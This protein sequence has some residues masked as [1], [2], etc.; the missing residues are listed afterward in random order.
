MEI[1]LTLRGA[2]QNQLGAERFE[3][4]FG[5]GIRFK[6][7][8]DR[9][10]A[11]ASSQFL[12]EWL[13][14]NFRRVL[15]ETAEKVLGRQVTV[16]IQVGQPLPAAEISPCVD[17]EPN[18][19]ESAASHGKP[20]PQQLEASLPAEVAPVNVMSAAFQ[21]VTIPFVTLPKAAL[22][23]TVVTSAAPVG[24]PKTDDTGRSTSATGSTPRKFATFETFVVGESNRFGWTAAQLASERRGNFS[25]LLLYGGTG[26]GKTHLMEAI[27]S[28]LRHGPERRR[29]V[30]LT[31]EQFT[32]YFVDAVRRSG[33]PNFRRKYRGV[34]LLLID[35]LQFFSGKRATLVELLYTINTLTEEGRQVV[36][37]ADRPPSELGEL[38]RELVNRL[39][40]G[41]VCG[42]EAPDYEV[43]SGIVRQLV[44]A[45]GV[46]F[47]PE[48]E[49]FV[50]REVIADARGL[51]GAVNRLVVTQMTLAG[52]ITQPMAQEVLADLTRSASRSVRLQDIDSAICDV[53]GLGHA[54]L[55]SPRRTKDVTHPRMLAM[56]L[57]RKHTRA[58][59]SEIGN[60]F[61]GRSHST[62]VSAQQ[63]VGDWMGERATLRI[64]DTQC[65]I[66]EA[67]RRVE[68]KLLG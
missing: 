27:W 10:I 15:E 20:S 11:V 56:W 24:R 61:G 50:A 17:R 35:D 12:Q 38:G 5:K 32:S 29:A 62:V 8:G 58:A 2:L 46:R 25:S 36:L 39:Q 30:Y 54:S 57:A 41:M 45:S 59:L 49:N 33:L 52:P 21:Q 53:F 31:A 4:W 64:A 7:E 14:R 16:E 9:V 55:Q 1:D 40:G 37:S 65:S 23:N 19:S 43:R 51:A 48:V 18:C 22:P 42:L 47:A 13:R 34:D 26:V 6:L 63:K 44:A 3:L 28:R 68:R 67:I 66:D 60:Y